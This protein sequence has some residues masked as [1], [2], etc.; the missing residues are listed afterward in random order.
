MSGIVDTRGWIPCRFVSEDVPLSGYKR[1]QNADGS[2]SYSR[3][4][5]QDE[6]ER[7]ASAALAAIREHKQYGQANAYVPPKD[8]P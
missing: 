6:Q 1:T 4:L 2:V 8:T 7:F 5:G 3:T